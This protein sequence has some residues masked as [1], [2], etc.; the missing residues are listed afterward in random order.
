VDGCIV[1]KLFIN[2]S[3]I[4]S[5]L[6]ASATRGA[7]VFPSA[8]ALRVALQYPNQ[9]QNGNGFILKGKAY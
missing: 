5:C 9:Y 7:S 2:F 3:H 8:L 4:A 6:R 1:L